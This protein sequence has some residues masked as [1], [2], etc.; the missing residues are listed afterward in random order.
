[1]SGSQ[2][3]VSILAGKGEAVLY[4]KK[5]DGSLSKASGMSPATC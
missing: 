4:Q 2:E 1:M 3:G 5:Q